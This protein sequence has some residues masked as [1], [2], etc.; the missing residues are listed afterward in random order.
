MFTRLDLKNM[1]RKKF[2][3]HKDVRF[4]IEQVSVCGHIIHETCKKCGAK[5]DI[6]EGLFSEY[7]EEWL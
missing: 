3:E 6:Y 1:F 2:C 4:T 7:K 5:R